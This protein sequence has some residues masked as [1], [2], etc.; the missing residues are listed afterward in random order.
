MCAKLFEPNQAKQIETKVPL[1][2]KVKNISQKVTPVF[3]KNEEELLNLIADL[4]VDI[5]M[6]EDV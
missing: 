5:I 4:I 1:H 3:I 6:E 2:K